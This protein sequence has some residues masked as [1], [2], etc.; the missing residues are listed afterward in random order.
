M[1]RLTARQLALPVAVRPAPLPRVPLLAGL[2]ELLPEEPAGQHLAEPVGG[3]LLAELQPRVALPA[4]QRQQV[5]LPGERLPA[6]LP[7]PAEERQ[8]QVR[9]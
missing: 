1:S 4:E 6:G 2:L 9:P 7:Q 3:L 8:P 5:A